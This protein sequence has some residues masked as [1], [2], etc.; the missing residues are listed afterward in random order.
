MKQIVNNYLH[1]RANHMNPSLS[2]HMKRERREIESMS[3]EKT[4]RI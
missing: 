1:D 4:D 3:A 2:D